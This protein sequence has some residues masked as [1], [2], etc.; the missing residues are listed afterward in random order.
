VLSTAADQLH[1]QEAVDGVVVGKPSPFG[2]DA[3]ADGC[4]VSSSKTCVLCAP[5]CTRRHTVEP[6]RL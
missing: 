4:G 3:D 1:V 2:G 5:G 6:M